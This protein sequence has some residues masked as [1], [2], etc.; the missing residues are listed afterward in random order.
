[1][2]RN[3]NMYALLVEIKTGMT[4]LVNNLG[5]FSEVKCE[6]YGHNLQPEST[7]LANCL[8][9]FPT[10]PQGGMY[11]DGHNSIVCGSRN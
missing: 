4:I 9:S 6:K 10:C 8:G 7:V 2:G 11:K 3:W 5:V 1:M